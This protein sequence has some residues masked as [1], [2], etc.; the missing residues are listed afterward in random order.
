MS[1]FWQTVI[2]AVLTALVAGRVA[3]TRTSRLR[4]TIDANLA[5]L[6]R[7]PADHP[8]R[9]TLEAHNGELLDLLV[10]R[11]QRRFGPFTQAGVSFGVLAGVTIVALIL[12]CGSALLAV[13]V[14]PS[15]AAADPPTSGDQWAAVGFLLIV[16]GGYAAAAVIAARRQL[17]E[18]P[19]QL[20]RDLGTNSTQL[21]P[22]EAG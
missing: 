6:D 14:L 15:A 9:P 4:R 20:E 2:P 11:Q 10:R 7:L 22:S 5:L 1:A 16:A 13:G 19:V 12:A 18:H 3:W 21:Q 8:N 17:R